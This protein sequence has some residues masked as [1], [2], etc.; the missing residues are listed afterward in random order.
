MP[1]IIT[2]RLKAARVL[3][4]NLIGTQQATPEMAS[5]YAC[6]QMNLPKDLQTSLAQYA[7]ELSQQTATHTMQPVDMPSYADAFS[8]FNKPPHNHETSN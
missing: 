2:E 7:S 3:I 1:E 6:R 8:K 4:A 5:R